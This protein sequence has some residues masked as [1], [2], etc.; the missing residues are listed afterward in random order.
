MCV[1]ENIYISYIPYIRLRHATIVVVVVH[2]HIRVGGHSAVQI[3]ELCVQRQKI[4]WLLAQEIRLQDVEDVRMAL[5]MV[6]VVH[7]VAA[8]IVIVDVVVIIIIIITIVVA[9]VVHVAV[10]A[11]M[12]RTVVGHL[13]MMVLHVGAGKAIWIAQPQLSCRIDAYATDVAA[14]EIGTA[15]EQEL[16][17]TLCRRVWTVD[18]LAF[19]R[20][21][22][23]ICSR[24]ANDTE[25][26]VQLVE[27]VVVADGAILG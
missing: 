16:V 19:Q 26:L 7:V 13:H 17:S 5:S 9:V 20:E 21:L 14:I 10:M 1:Y 22:A 15:V 12:I 11:V 8:G 3:R 27:V 25:L 24:S 18:V 4:R 2:H 23:A 6:V